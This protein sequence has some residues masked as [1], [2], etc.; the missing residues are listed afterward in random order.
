MK[1][2]FSLA[3]LVGGPLLSLVLVF[4]LAVGGYYSLQIFQ[5]QRLVCRSK[6]AELRQVEDQIRELQAQNALLRSQQARLQTPQG[7]EEVAREKLGMVRP[8]EIA[9]VV[10]PGPPAE[11]VPEEL[12]PAPP[13]LPDPGLFQ[14][15]LDHLLF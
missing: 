5:Q 9:F 13:A 10:E 2:R 4:L 12:P 8:G 14:R 15:V 6:Q 1:R 11:S 7:M 3:R